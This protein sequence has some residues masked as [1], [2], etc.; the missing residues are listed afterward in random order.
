MSEADFKEWLALASHDADTVDLLIRQNGHADIII[1]HVHQAVEKSLKAL[2]IKGGQTFDKT[3]FLD[4]LLAKAVQSYPE[5]TKIENEVLA[6]N[7]YLPKLRYPYGDVIEFS[8]A[9]I[10]HDK[11]NR[12]RQSML[13]LLD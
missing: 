12:I 3:H 4:K 9:L 13:P 1:Y 7:L 6:I 2:L 10:V 5:L 8:E 11:F